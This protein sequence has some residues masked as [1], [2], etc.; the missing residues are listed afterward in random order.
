MVRRLLLM[1][2]L[3]VLGAVVFHATGWGFT[4][5]I[6]WRERYVA[7]APVPDFSQVG[8]A[9][10]YLLRVAEQVALVGVP[11]FLFVSGF[12]IA[13]ASGRQGRVEWSTVEA[14]LRM[15][16]P[17][18]VLWSACILLARV[19]EGTIAGPGSFA[20]RLVL[21]QAA[22]PYYYVPAITQL[23]LLAPVIVWGLKHRPAS[24]LGLAGLVQVL[25]QAVRYPVLLGHDT[26]WVVW[27][28]GH[29]PSWFF[30]HL[31]FWFT[32]GVF[33]GLHWTA[34]SGWLVRVRPV[35]PWLTGLLAVV[36]F[37]EW[38]LLLR[39][40]SLPWLPAT[41]TVLDSLFAAALVLCFLSGAWPE[42]PASVRRVLEQ[43]GERS[44][45]VYLL[46]VLVLEFLARGAYH[47]A[48]MLLA[49]PVAFH[50]LLVAG[51]L[52]VPMLAM[53]VV[54]RSPLRP[55]YKLLFG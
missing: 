54:D 50:V 43:V 10:Y 32:L 9:G 22:E 1:N 52:G 7:G 26:P 34:L 46:H 14:R 3:A 47:A 25:V 4:A 28:A 42:L 53:A 37:V 8:T 21:G 51:G 48:P 16:L 17:P 31:V 36:A 39:A 23:F 19:V 15:L 29:L 55:A 41:T 33:A 40:S 2:G 35:L 38:E 6:W 30:P 18:F 20:R 27:I 24:T 49:H 5:L 45:G 44:Y 11:A 13:F 12:F